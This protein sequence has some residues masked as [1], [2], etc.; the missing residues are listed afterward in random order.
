MSKVDPQ[1]T[2]NSQ[3]V[4][5]PSYAKA[6]ALIMDSALGQG[7]ERK[8][9]TK[10]DNAWRMFCSGKK[11]SRKNSLQQLDVALRQL[12]S[13]ATKQIA[14][15]VRDKL[16][17]AI[18]SLRDC[19][20]GA[21]PIRMA[22]LA[23]R[24][25]QPTMSGSPGK[26]ATAGVIIRVNN[27]ELGLTGAD[28]TATVSVPA[29]DILV[30]AR[31]YPSSAGQAYLTL[32]PDETRQVDI[33]LDDG[34][35]LAEDTELV[36]DQLQDGVLD[37]SFTAF[38]LRFLN[39]T[40]TVPL[41]GRFYV[42][43]L[44][45][46]GGRPTH[47][48]SYFSVQADGTL[49]ATD[50]TRLK[51]I[52]QQR[53]GAIDISVEAIDQGKRI[54]RGVIRLYMSRY[55]AVCKLVAPPSFPGLVTS[56]IHVTAVI[57]N[58]NL[59]FN[60]VSDA[61]GA[62]E[63]PLLPTGTL[64]LDSQ[65]IQDGKYYYGLGVVVVKSSMSIAVN[66]L[67]TQDVI[68][69]VPKLQITPLAS[70]NQAGPGTAAKSDSS[71]IETYEETEEIDET[72]LQARRELAEKLESERQ[73][74]PPSLASTET[75]TD[76]AVVSVVAGR[77]N[78]PKIDLATLLVPKDTKKVALN[79]RV[80]TDEYPHYVLSQ[81]IYN[82]TWTVEVRHDSGG[83]LLFHTVRQINSQLSM[84]PIWQGDGTT[85]DIE[86]VL[87]V[88]ALTKEQDVTL[89]LV[90]TA[91]NV[92]DSILPTR[93]N[94]TLGTKLSVNIHSATPEMDINTVG[95]G[96]YFSIPRPDYN[97]YFK[98]RFKIK[99][100]KPETATIKSVKVELLA[101]G[102]LMTIVDEGVG[103][104]VE[105]VDE[106]TLKVVVT[107]EA[108]AS[109]IPSEP[110]TF[111]RFKYR[112]KL[113][114]EENGEEASDEKES[115]ECYALWEMP[116][117][118]PRY[119]IRDLGGDGWC[120]RGTYLW[121]LA[122]RTLLVA[123]NDISGEHARNIVH[124]THQYGTDIDMLHY[125][126][127]DGVESGGGNYD[128]LWFYAATAHF[129]DTEEYIRPWVIATRQGLDR[130]AANP[131]VQEIYYIYGDPS[132]GSLVDPPQGALVEGWAK[133]LLQTGKLIYVGEEVDLGLGAWSNPKYTPREINDHND[134]IH[135]ILNR[136]MIDR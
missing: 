102:P 5:A 51:S 131:A 119:S 26:P 33:V 62:F 86:E 14:P 44:N 135:I 49:L 6:H 15:A 50:L 29:G 53:T 65:T 103:E 2:L 108:T 25:F 112:F 55:R 91:M 1:V 99:Y 4:C 98:R 88:S 126:T 117:G 83:L 40:A 42:E 106:G 64:S 20:N 121:L 68:R 120:S 104:L 34:K 75:A 56:G 129:T 46:T 52:L 36:L 105:E 17:G 43:L 109:T 97:N 124:E 87:D 80:Q 72:V 70:S 39:D 90:A 3:Q 110:P 66:M 125:Y 100:T 76:E 115:V 81:S 122:N 18:K 73:A 136:A 45:P 111:H 132:Q 54:H 78:D 37:R 7:L 89:S 93:V 130:L 107:M 127:F 96:R 133:I 24:I 13:P 74:P 94:A 35:Q 95:D 38:T 32:A 12:D 8:L 69:G 82:D 30:E 113:T 10:V 128:L 60:A 79:Y 77:E 31:L 134:H 28:G 41:Q 47:L 59:V 48:E 123:I 84:H 101:P 114:V 21:P 22:T 57:L 116:N 118:F 67:H 61:N 11:N 58:T 63:L 19:L 9:I 23:V 92:G 16:L 85:G 27:V 71:S